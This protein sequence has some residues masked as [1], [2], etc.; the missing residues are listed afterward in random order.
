[1]QPRNRATMSGQL[2][3]EVIAASPT[4]LKRGLS[5]RGFHALIAIAEKCHTQTRQGSVGWDHIRDCLYGASRRTAQRAVHDLLTAGVLEIVKPGF[6]NQYGRTCAPIYQIAPLVDNDTWVAQ[7]NKVDDDTQMSRSNEVDDD[8][9]KVHDDKP[10][11]GSRHPG[12][13]LDRPID[14]GV[15]PQPGTSPDE[16]QPSTDPPPQKP[17]PNNKT[18]T[19]NHRATAHATCPT[20]QT[21]TAAAAAS[22][23]ASTTPGRE[24]PS[25]DSPHYSTPSLDRSTPATTATEPANSSTAPHIHP[26]PETPQLQAT[27]HRRHARQAQRTQGGPRRMTT[28]RHHALAAR[29]VLAELTYDDDVRSRVSIDTQR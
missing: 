13:V 1:M 6:G 16:S 10:G 9:S 14:G 11:S 7:S 2:V 19:P 23:A 17:S 12:V 21:T 22:H 5:E 20:A 4:F 18:P 3:G 26:V 24:E 8:K 27:P 29:L 25:N 28:A 15:S